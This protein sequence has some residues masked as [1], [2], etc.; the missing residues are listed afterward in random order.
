MKNLLIFIALVAAL[1]LSVS[2]ATAQATK[3]AFVDSEKILGELPEAQ[4]ASAELNALVKGWQDSVA[5]MQADLAKQVEEYQKQSSVMAQIKKD[6]EEK[7]LG[8]LN[9]RLREFATAKLDTRTGE[10][11]QEREK[12]LTPIR[13]K[14]LRSIEAVAKEDGF[15]FVFDRANVLYADA[16]VD[17]T[18]K[19]ID[20]L[21]RGAAG[22]T[23]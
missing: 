2:V 21:K 19:V 22:K 23:K 9:Q 11:A 6:A 14:V 18:Y 4:K 5:A 10:A 16:K 8:E 17:L 1:L 7:R 20:R 3:A 13:E 15:T 12:R